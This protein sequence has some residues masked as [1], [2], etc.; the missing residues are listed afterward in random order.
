MNPEA[1]IE[2]L[3]GTLSQVK[4]KSEASVMIA[5]N[6]KVRMTNG[7][8][9]EKK[10]ESEKPRFRIKCASTLLKELRRRS[11]NRELESS[12]D[13]LHGRKKKM[14]GFLRDGPQ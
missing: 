12:F 7:R 4:K 1:Q 9:T 6:S 3:E 14:T 13:E 5:R 11:C 2:D 8:K 10:K